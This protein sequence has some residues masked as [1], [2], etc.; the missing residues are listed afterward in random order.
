MAKWMTAWVN[1][2]KYLGK[3]VIPKDFRN[4][5][6]S[7]QAIVDGSLPGKESPGS[8]FSNYGFG[9]FMDSYKGHYRVEHGGNIDGFS[10]SSCFFPADSI[11]IVVLTN[12]NGSQVPGIVRNIISDRVLH[13]KY[14]DWNSKTKNEDDKADQARDKEQQKTTKAAKHNPSTRPLAGFAG[15][16]SHPAYGTMKVYVEN[17]SLF[18]KTTVRTL[19]LR[20]VNYDTFEVLDKD[21]KEGIDTA[22]VYGIKLQFHMNVSGDIDSFESQLEDGLKPFFFVREKEVKKEGT[23]K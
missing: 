23:L 7:S 12:Q 21:P 6:I 16:Y 13:L 5:A 18:A 8:Y 9:W 20:H 11:G 19:W 10:A 14:Q 22:K 15:R 17:D 4:E 2:G 3:E 1:N